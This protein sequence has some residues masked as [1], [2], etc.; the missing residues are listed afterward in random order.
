MTAK[1]SASVVNNLENAD[2]VASN[3]KA[4]KTPKTNPIC[5][6]MFNVSHYQLLE[7]QSHLLGNTNHIVRTLL[8]SIHQTKS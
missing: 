7:G 6:G 4:T 8:L 2:K 3:N 1:T 5:N